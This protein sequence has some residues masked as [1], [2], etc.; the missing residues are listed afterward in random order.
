MGS[1][2]PRFIPAPQ[3]RIGVVA[4]TH[5]WMHPE[6]SDALRGVDLIVHVGDIGDPGILE[7]LRR[8]APV[9]AVRGNMDSEPWACTLPD[10]V[11]IEAGT[12]R[13]LMVHDA[14]RVKPEQVAAHDA[15]IV[16]HSHLAAQEKR[17]GKLF[18]NPGTA[19]HAR[20]GRP[21]SVGLLQIDCGRIDGEIVLLEA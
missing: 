18:F 12:A 19:G 14:D 15:V 6:V 17:S 16:G 9:Q 21:V 7:E 11:E 8:I 10:E 2:K 5:G 13:I 20:P 3:C 4:D 1:Q